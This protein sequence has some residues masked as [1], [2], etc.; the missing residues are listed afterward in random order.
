MK[1]IYCFLFLLAG[2]SRYVDQEV[3]PLPPSDSYMIISVDARH[4]DYSSTRSFIQSMTL[5]DGQVGHAWL[6]FKHG[7]VYL[8]G[9]HSG[10]LGITQPRYC[11]SIQNNIDYGYPNPTSYDKR[12]P[13]HEPNP[14][15][16]LWEC[17]NDGFFQQGSGQHPTTFSL[18]I[19]LDAETADK[20]QKYI[21]TYPFHEYSLT[22]Y[23]CTSFCVQAAAIAGLDLED[24]ITLP[25]DQYV[26]LGN[27]IYKLWEDPTYSVITFSSPDVLE[28]SL[29]KAGK[30]YYDSIKL[31]SSMGSRPK[32]HTA[33]P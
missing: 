25:I 32:T 27:R 7:D 19:P 4:L 33:V 13:R 6:T 8:E 3:I 16:C 21:E 26:K 28:A 18:Y 22:G 1:L 31:Q 29:K 11:D 15:K 20:I 12:H 30:S 23:Q 2:C 14:I 5:N 17:Q 9:G 10:E 24:Q